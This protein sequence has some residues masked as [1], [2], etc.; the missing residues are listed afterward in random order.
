MAAPPAGTDL[1]ALAAEL[2]RSPVI[3]FA[4]ATGPAATR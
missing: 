2:R 1:D 4:E 3:A